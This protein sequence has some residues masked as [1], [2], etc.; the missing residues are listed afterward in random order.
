MTHK[1]KKQHEKNNKEQQ[2][3]QV[4]QDDHHDNQPNEQQQQEEE[5]VEPKPQPL[6]ELTHGYAYISLEG[7]YIDT[8]GY[9]RHG[10][11]P[12]L[13]QNRIQ[14]DGHD[15]SHITLIHRKELKLAMEAANIEFPK[16]KRKAQAMKNLIQWIMERVGEPSQWKEYDWPMDL[17]LA[18][19]EKQ[20]EEQ[21]QKLTSKAY[22]RVLHWPLGQKIRALLNL[23][24]AFFHVT[25]GFDPKDVHGIYKGPGTL[26]CLKEQ[27][28]PSPLSHHIRFDEVQKEQQ[29]MIHD[30]T[31]L[32]Y[33]APHYTKDMVFLNALANQC[34]CYREQLETCRIDWTF[35]QQHITRN[36]NNNNNNHNKDDDTEENWPE[37]PGASLSPSSSS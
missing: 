19:V 36:N 12:S 6:I 10:I 28:Y 21:Q 5:V 18:H 25:I 27:Q 14:R 8:I 3:Q 37:A 35:I 33:I 16:K 2:E 26:L 1:K 4:T 15:H 34:S 30:L 7:F 32:L 31:R 29:G 20:E 11:S 22:Y 17:G 24:P 9:Q 23:E 13:I